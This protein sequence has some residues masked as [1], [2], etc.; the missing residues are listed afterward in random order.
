MLRS[1]WGPGVINIIIDLDRKLKSRKPNYK[2]ACEI[3]IMAIIEHD[4]PFSF[5]EYRRFTEFVKVFYPEYVPISRKAITSN[6]QKMHLIEKD[7]LKKGLERI[8][9]RVC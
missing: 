5:I 1:T 9:S 8:P 2:H 3:M 4:L 7:K 6:M